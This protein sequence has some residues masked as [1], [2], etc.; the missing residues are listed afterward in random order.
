MNRQ[1][2]PGWQGIRIAELPEV[3]Q[4]TLL[5][6]SRL[7]DPYH[8]ATTLNLASAGFFMDRSVLSGFRFDPLPPGW[9]EFGMAGG[10][11]GR[12][13]QLG[14][15][16][17]GASAW[18]LLFSWNSR[19]SAWD[20]FLETQDALKPTRLS[21]MTSLLLPCLLLVRMADLSGKQGNTIEAAHWVRCIAQ[22]ERRLSQL[23]TGF[24]V[25]WMTGASEAAVRYTT[26]T[27]TYPAL[28]TEQWLA[29][30]R[31]ERIFGGDLLDVLQT[32]ERVEPTIIRGLEAAGSRLW[33]DRSLAVPGQFHFFASA[34]LPFARWRLDPVGPPLPP[35]DNHGSLNAL[36][37]AWQTWKRG[38]ALGE[39]G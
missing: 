36:L 18:V 23:I 25:E 16:R 35:P 9:T 4:F 26:E 22:A 3:S 29:L 13:A 27:H 37:N 15:Y 20:A 19:G 12:E 31:W 6:D 32:T 33:T 21:I 24:Y 34:L 14:G 39:H 11:S 17:A 2:F 5:Y 30:G 38:D 10:P 28:T 1:Q 7:I 8:V